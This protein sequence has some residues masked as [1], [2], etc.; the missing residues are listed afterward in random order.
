MPYDAGEHIKAQLAQMEEEKY[1]KCPFCG[2]RHHYQDGDLEL[3]DDID[4]AERSQEP[5]S[6]TCSE[7]DLDFFVHVMVT[8]SF[9]AKRCVCG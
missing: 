2:E 9:E 5:F 7:C 4:K 3:W 1:I 8:R 6:M